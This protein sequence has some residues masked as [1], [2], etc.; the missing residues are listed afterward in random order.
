MY[1]SITKALHVKP[2]ANIKFNSEKKKAFL[3]PN[4]TARQ[5]VHS[6]HFYS[7]WYWEF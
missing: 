5:G 3:S 4:I 7:T 6:H 1:L 2:T